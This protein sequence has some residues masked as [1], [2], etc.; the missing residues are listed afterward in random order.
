VP[1]L[2]AYE[3]TM[4]HGLVQGYP[5]ENYKKNAIVLAAGTRSLVVARAAG[6]PMAFGTDLIGELDDHQ[7]DEF[8]IRARVLSNA[9]SVRAA[10]TTAAE[11]LR[12][13]GELGVIASGA[14][15][16]ILVLDKNPLDDISVL[17]SSGKDLRV[18]MRDGKIHKDNLG[19]WQ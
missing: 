19:L 3:A 15:A 11:V 14:F 8:L 6:V 4:K 13:T 1:T 7:C 18:I 12:R 9:E 2:V 10:T 17:A 5:E 16:D